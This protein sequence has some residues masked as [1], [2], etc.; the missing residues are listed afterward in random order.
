MLILNIIGIFVIGV[1][2][3]LKFVIIVVCKVVF[4][5]YKNLIVRCYYFVKLMQYD[6]F[7]DQLLYGK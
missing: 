1:F 3:W 7:D 2:L 4:Y 6:G 5:G